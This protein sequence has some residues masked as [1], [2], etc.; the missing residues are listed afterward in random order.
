MLCRKNN[1][2][3]TNCLAVVIIF[4]GYLC[5]AVRSQIRQCT[6]LTNLC[7][8]TCKLMCQSNWIW[9]IFFSFICCK[10][11]HH[12]LVTGTDSRNFL[13]RHCMF[14]GFKGFIN[15]HSNICRLLVK[16]YHY[17]TCICIETI[18][19]S[20]ITN[21]SDCISDDILDIDLCIRCDLTHNHNKTC[22]C[23]C[24]ASYTAHWILFQHCIKN[25]IRNLI[26]DL[27]RMA[28]CYRFR[29]E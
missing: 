19:T 17:C 14:F 26:T 9:H 3:Q 27:V 15:T 21:F 24:F 13:F 6:I 28:F 7:Q 1:S 10:T 2:I 20:C 5:F 4:N 22:C 25:S 29:C 18:F 11:E 23:T 16:R 8:L 12:T